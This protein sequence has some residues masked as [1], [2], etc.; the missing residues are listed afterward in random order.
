MRV[1]EAVRGM[2][3]FMRRVIS[4][5]PMRICLFT[6]TFLP[7]VGG[8]ARSVTTFLE[9]FRR[10]GHR[11]LVVAPEFAEG[12]APRG[13]E[14]SVVRVP[15]WRN[16]NGSDFSVSL[17]LGSAVT[18]RIARFRPHLIHAQHP[19]L[20]G[21]S[22][23]RIAAERGIPV[24]FTHHTLY[25]QYTHY[26]P[27]DSAPLQA[28]VIELATRF[29]NC[30]QGVIAPSAS[31][32]ALLKQRGVTVPVK[33]LPSGIDTRAFAT[34]SRANGRRR[35]HLPGDAVL[36]GHVGRLAAEKNLPFLADALARCLAREPRAHALVVGD[37]PARAE[38]EA[39]FARRRVPDRVHFAGVLTG[40]DLHDAYAA[41]DVFAFSSHSE[42]QGMVLTEAMA[43]GCPVVAL[44]ASGV[45]DV[46]RD[47]E[48]GRLLPSGASA[49]SLARA[50]T[51]AVRDASLR[52]QWRRGAQQTAQAFDRRVTAV[53]ALAFYRE[54]VK[55]HAP[56]AHRDTGEWDSWW[57]QVTGRLTIEGRMLSD[58]IAAA[59]G[60]LITGIAPAEE[61]PAA[62]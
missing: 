49:E 32:A 27:F 8:V 48:N 2:A 23:L 40:G 18:D 37:G 47:R 14:R 45:R 19:F 15:A 26:V 53:Q 36:L 28:F 29:A 13:I 58:K 9:D 33:V 62:G 41:M 31:L 59:A 44:D 22:A 43:A 25:E 54:I 1:P 61:L 39:V 35:L 30:C 10:A 51:T 21:D 16:F 12:P 4:I 38:V 20:L 50:L 34:A 60:A 7:H 55:A 5:S 17:P 57:Q 46:V 11:V 6:N 3:R 24:L 56:P 42:T 52:V